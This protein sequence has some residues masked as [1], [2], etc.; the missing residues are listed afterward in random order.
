MHTG[1][2]HNLLAEGT[3][4]SHSRSGMPRAKHSA[5]VE[6][7]RRGSLLDLKLGNL[8]FY[9][10]RFHKELNLTKAKALAGRQFYFLNKVSI[11]KG[12]IRGAQIAQCQAVV[13]QENLAMD[14]GD[15]GMLN[16]K[17]VIGTSSEAIA[18]QLELEDSSRRR[19][20][21]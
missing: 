16:G 5:V 21:F 7:H 8:H 20:R 3:L 2:A 11:Q 9:F 17:I 1:I 10:S 6:H 14:R 19:S 15:G 4:V 13:T 18:S 12:A